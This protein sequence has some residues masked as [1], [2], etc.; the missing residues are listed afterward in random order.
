MDSPSPVPRANPPGTAAGSR[1]HPRAA[2]PTPSSRTAISSCPPSRAG[3][4]CDRQPQPPAVRHRA[5]RVGREVPD[6]LPD[7]RLRPPGSTPARPARR[8][9]SR[10]RRQSLGAVL[11]QRRGVGHDLPDV[12]QRRRLALRPRV[13]EEAADRLVQPL[14]LADH[15]VHQLRLLVGQR[16]LLPQD[17]NRA[18]HRRQRVADLV[19]D[20]GGHLPDRRQPLLDARLPLR[21]ARFGDVAEREHEAGL[22]AGR[23][24]DARCSARARSAGRPG[25]S[26]RTRGAAALAA[27]PGREHRA[28]SAGGSCSTRQST[29]R[30]AA[31]AATPVIASAARLNVRSRP[32]DVGRRQAAGQAVDHVLA[33]GLQVRQLVRRLLAAARRPGAGPPPGTRSAPRP[34]GT[35]RR[36]ARR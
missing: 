29:A 23:P 6:D 2:I 11:Q 7:L 17:L 35:R 24:Q 12:H 4:A 31:A 14:G 32:P 25:A 27:R 13:R 1:R 21:A 34:R 3:S 5:Q 28:D 30:R 36:S 26:A 9:R 15:D 16:Q 10:A 8:R 22:A 33:E 20:S 19:G 18:G